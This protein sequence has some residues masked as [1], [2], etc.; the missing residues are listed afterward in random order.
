MEN[1]TYIGDGIYR[2]RT[3]LK[4][5]PLVGDRFEYTGHLLINKYPIGSEG[6]IVSI[7]VH[8]PSCV[9]V[10]MDRSLIERESM[11]EEWIAIFEDR[12]YKLTGEKRVKRRFLGIPFGSRTI[13]TYE[14]VT[15]C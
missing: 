11:P 8:V 7:E 10:R 4:R 6:V 2:E 5:Q 12:Y 15:E 1:L 3:Y 14:E 9:F 13:Q